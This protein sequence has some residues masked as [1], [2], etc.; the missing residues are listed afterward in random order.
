MPQMGRLNIKVQT[1]F[2]KMSIIPYIMENGI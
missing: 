1:Y 2:A